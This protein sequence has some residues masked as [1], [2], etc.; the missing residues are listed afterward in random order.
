[1]R[2][3]HSQK[4]MGRFRDLDQIHADLK[5]PKHLADYKNTKAAADLPGLGQFYCV[6]CA[7]WFETEHSMVGHRKGSAHKRR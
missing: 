5:S 4:L 7:K 1:M 3:Q 2:S 6:E